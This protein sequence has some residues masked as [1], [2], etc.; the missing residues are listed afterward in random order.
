[1]KREGPE[2]AEESGRWRR[3]SQRWGW[4]YIFSKT[5]GRV[6]L[7]RI[8]CHYVEPNRPEG[9]FGSHTYIIIIIIFEKGSCRKTVLTQLDKPP[10][11]SCV[12]KFTRS[13]MVLTSAVIHKI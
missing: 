9:L 2:Q 4:V 3:D 6:V 11:D 5:A 1:M 10:V 8:Y 7:K 13:K 12:G